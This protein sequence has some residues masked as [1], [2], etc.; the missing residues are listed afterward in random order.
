MC[1]IP[2]REVVLIILRTNKNSKATSLVGGDKGLTMVELLIAVMLAAIA[3]AGLY[4]F[5]FAGAQSWE[6]N[7]L[8]KESHQNARLAIRAV[9]QDLR[10]ADWVWIGDKWEDHWRDE[11]YVEPGEGE[12]IY[13]IFWGD[14]RSGE[15]RPHLIFNKI[16][17]D[18]QNT[19]YLR[20]K[21]LLTEQNFVYYVNPAPYYLA[22]NINE[23][24]FSYEDT[25]KEK[26]NI[27]IKAG[28]EDNSLTEL[29]SSVFL[30]N[31]K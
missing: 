12:V 11:D 6:R 27:M 25:D 4:S 3:T 8:Q 5:Y 16:W 29:Q 20:R 22:D 31:L 1:R 15:P 24:S 21:V 19:V 2:L 28:R 23:L 17:L 13:Y 18:M 14:K 30:R 26:L 7:T 9:E 10:Y